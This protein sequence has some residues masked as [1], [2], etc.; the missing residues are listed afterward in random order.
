MLCW[1]LLHCIMEVQITCHIYLSLYSQYLKLLS[2]IKWLLNNELFSKSFLKEQIT[3]FW[4]YFSLTISLKAY[5]LHFLNLSHETI[6]LLDFKAKWA[7]QSP[8]NEHL[9]HSKLLFALHLHSGINYIKY[10]ITILRYFFLYVYEAKEFP[11]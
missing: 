3:C 4:K 1:Y 5:L 6:K 11:L 9:K 2:W 8:V 10:I 7:K